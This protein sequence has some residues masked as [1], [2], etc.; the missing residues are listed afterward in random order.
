MRK[1][2]GYYHNIDNIKIELKKY[3]EQTGS[4]DRFKLNCGSLANGI[5]LNNLDIKSLIEDIGY[6]YNDIKPKYIFGEYNNIEAVK[7]KIQDFINIHNRFPT[8]TELNKDLKISSHYIY[9]YFKS[10]YEIKRQM[11]YNDIYDLVDKNGFYNKSVYELI[12]A[13]YLFDK[14]ITYKREQHPFPKEENN[15]ISD[16]TFYYD[17]GK[18]IHC[19][20][21]GGYNKN[22]KDFFLNYQKTMNIK[23]ELYNKYNINLISI[24][25]DIFNKRYKDIITELD[26]IFGNFINVQLDTVNIQNF[27]PSNKLS[28][29]EILKILCENFDCENGTLPSAEILEKSEFK[30][31]YTQILKRY[32]NYREFALKFDKETMAKRNYWNS[33]KINESFLY[34]CNTFGKI[35]NQNEIKKYNI[36]N[37]YQGLHHIISKSGIPFMQYRLNFYDYCIKSKIQLP[38]EEIN[39]LINFCKDRKNNNFSQ[40]LFNNI[41]KVKIILKEMK[42]VV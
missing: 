10:V 20:I 7:V 40:L 30:G 17:D 42:L 13:N 39:Y 24:Y 33:D 31:L 4:L 29:E 21:W 36:I 18:I 15:Y 19:E 37:D 8:T 28:D 22:N 41:Q 26:K 9:T 35:L 6:N 5:K 34:M 2:R 11:N 1:T 32:N 14:N 38:Q 23:K 12:V 27:I 3:I 16:F 25:P